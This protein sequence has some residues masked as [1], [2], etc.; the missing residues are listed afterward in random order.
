MNTPPSLDK[1]ADDPSRAS[2]LSLATATALLARVSVV[3]AALTARAL[4]L[5][6]T[7]TS[8][9]EADQLLDV[10]VA[11]AKLGVSTSYLYRHAGTLPFTVRVGRGLRFSAQG[12]DRYIEGHQMMET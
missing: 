3:Q 11:A 6:F 10:S 1:L 5:A 4:A 8:A 12:I 9:A 2:T 7:P